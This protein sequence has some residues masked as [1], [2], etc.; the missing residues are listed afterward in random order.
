MKAAE[1]PNPVAGGVGESQQPEVPKKR[2]FNPNSDG[3]TPSWTD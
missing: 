3:Y 1:T 2:E